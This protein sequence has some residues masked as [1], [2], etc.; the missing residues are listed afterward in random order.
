VLA[1]ATFASTRSANRSARIADRVARTAERSLLA[2]QR[3][4]LVNSRLADPKQN[5]QFSE[6]KLLTVCGGEATLEVSGDAIYMALAARNVGTGLAVLH[7]WYVQDGLP[8]SRSHPPVE[9]F[10]SQI[11]DIYLPPGDIGFWQGLCPIRRPRHR[12]SRWRC[13]RRSKRRARR[14]HS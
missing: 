12:R 11:R 1:V 8:T 14:P 4:L 7:G 10:T 6:G 13:A 3:P 2:G 9:E 5:V